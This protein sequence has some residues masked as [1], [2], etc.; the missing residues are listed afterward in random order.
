VNILVSTGTGT[1]ADYTVTATVAY[2]TAD[3]SAPSFQAMAYSL[4]DGNAADTSDG[5]IYSYYVPSGGY[6]ANGNILAYS[7]SVMG[8]WAYSYDPMNRLS[9]GVAAA[10]PYAGQYGCWGYDSFGNRELGS[11]QT[12]PCSTSWTPNVQFNASNQVKLA[13]SAASGFVYDAQGDVLAD[14]L[15][16][17]AYDGEGRLCAVQ[18]SNNSFSQYIYDAE[19][20]RTAKESLSEN[21][22]GTGTI[23]NACSSRATDTNWIRS[24]GSM[25]LSGSSGAAV[26][27]LG[28]SGNWLHTNAP[29]GAAMATYASTTTGVWFHLTDPLGTR[30]ILADAT[31]KVQQSCQSLPFGD[32][33]TCTATPTEQL[34]TGKER[35]TES[36]NDYF[37]ARYYASS[38]GR[39]LSPDDD[40]DQEP[41][42]PQSWNLYPYVRNNPLTNTDPDGHDCV[43]QSRIDDNHESVSVSS[44]TCSGVSVGSGQSATYVPGTVT[45]ISANGGNSIDI[46]YNSYDGQSSGVTNASSAPAFDHPGIDGPANAAIFGQ[47]GNQGMG[48]IKWFGEQMALNVAG[49]L[50]G[51]GIGLGLEALQATRLAK[52]AS[53]ATANLSSKILRQ[54]VSRGW[55]RQEIEETIQ[56]GTAHVIEGG[57]KATGG[58]VTEFVNSSGKF[59]VVDNSS[60]QVLQVSRTGMLPNHL[61]Q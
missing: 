26:T 3:F 32:G 27:E 56:Y 49:G 29:S 9:S 16:H 57:N 20:K 24:I 53:G 25:Y 55:T 58:T 19:G 54:M 37:G 50:V 41:S 38:M 48:A 13:P 33:E 61:V 8:D 22:G 18:N 17:Y 30:R 11:M 46:G 44:G 52:L 10:G 5:L 40:S 39:F 47:I 59:V 4:S 28:S 1:A 43:V 7:D 31:G 35:D 2:D 45:G 34:F 42:D 60:G 15:N 14:G 6:A 36:G 51:H 12:G 23:T 21:T